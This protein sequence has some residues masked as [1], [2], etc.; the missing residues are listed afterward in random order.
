MCAYS[1]LTPY[2]G[3]LTWFQMKKAEKI[4]SYDWDRYDQGHIVYRPD[5]MTPEML[6]EGHMR[7]YA[8]FYSLPSIARRFPIAGSRSR[9][10]WGIY[11]MFFRKGEVTG[12]HLGHAIAA[13]T[14]EPEF[15]P[16][17]PL[18]PLKREWRDIVVD[19]MGESNESKVA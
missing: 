19:G 3:T 15:I 17:P 4:V 18:L 1:V 13:P 10:Q 7:A 5:H 2:P 9:A 14:P 11:N 16:Q 6:R 8:N 12:R